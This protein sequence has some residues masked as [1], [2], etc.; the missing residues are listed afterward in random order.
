MSQFVNDL[1]P[2][3]LRNVVY[4]ILSKIIADKLKNVLDKIISPF[5]CAFVEG[6]YI[7]DNYIIANEVLHSFKKKHTLKGRDCYANEFK[8]IQK[9]ASKFY[10]LK[11]ALKG[12]SLPKPSPAHSLNGFKSSGLGPMYRS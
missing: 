2:I 9:E 6:R 1:R 8:I 5:Q 4:K 12:C 11:H 3:S 10:K 7:A